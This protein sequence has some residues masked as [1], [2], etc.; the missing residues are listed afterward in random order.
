MTSEHEQQLMEGEVRISRGKPLVS[1]DSGYGSGVSPAPVKHT[2][3]TVGDDE[4]VDGD[5][6]VFLFDTGV[7]ESEIDVEYNKT[8]H[9]SDESSVKKQKDVLYDRTTDRNPRAVS[10][11]IKI[12]QSSSGSRSM[13]EQ[14]RDSFLD[15]DEHARSDPVANSGRLRLYLRADRETQTDPG[16]I[17]PHGRARSRTVVKRE[18]QGGDEA[19]AFDLP[20]VIPQPRDRSVSMPDVQLYLRRKSEQRVGQRLRIISD[21]FHTA[22]VTVARN[23]QSPASLP[24]SFQSLAS[25]LRRMSSSFFRTESEQ[26][27]DTEP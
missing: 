21:E 13:E 25:G 15:I 17:Y 3:F 12:N 26:Q 22:R 8:M 6:N 10:A 16:N 23:S 7:H 5:D 27:P 24:S 19:A 18:D 9:N 4:D 1:G 11:P 14:Q 20:D 2:V